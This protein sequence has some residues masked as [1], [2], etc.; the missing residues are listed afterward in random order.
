[1]S[2]SYIELSGNDDMDNE[3]LEKIQQ[4]QEDKRREKFHKRRQYAKYVCKKMETYIIIP[5]VS[6][7]SIGIFVGLFVVTLPVGIPIALLQ[8]YLTG[9]NLYNELYINLKK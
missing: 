2:K 7:V 3:I 6:L 1:M 9:N 8:Q 5:V 4:F